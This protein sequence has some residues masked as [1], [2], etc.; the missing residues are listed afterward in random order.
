MSS[1]SCQACGDPK[2]ACCSDGKGGQACNDGQSCVANFCPAS[3]PAGWSGDPCGSGAEK[4]QN[5]MTCNTSNKCE[6]GDASAWL[7]CTQDSKSVCATGGGPAPPPSGGC[8]G[9][10]PPA[11]ASIKPKASDPMCQAYG[12]NCTGTDGSKCSVGQFG[13]VGGG[14]LCSDATNAATVTTLYNSGG[15]FCFRAT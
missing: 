1:Y 11:A 6:C 13:Q 10:W 12:G 9:N 15:K 2:G 7:S 4:C 8:P 3:T 14:T 5:K